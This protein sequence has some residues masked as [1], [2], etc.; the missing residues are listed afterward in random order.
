MMETREGDELSIGAE[1]EGVAE[2]SQV[3][4]HLEAYQNGIGND[5]MFFLPSVL[6]DA[7]ESLD[8]LSSKKLWS[9]RFE[10]IFNARSISKHARENILNHFNQYL[11]EGGAGNYSTN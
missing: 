3:Y 9:I 4:E 1:E 7:A 5:P 11:R 10:T 8:E 2:A 6:P